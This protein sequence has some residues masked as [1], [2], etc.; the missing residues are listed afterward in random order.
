MDTKRVVQLRSMCIAELYIWS[1]KAKVECS[2]S[3]IVSYNQNSTLFLSVVRSMCERKIWR[4]RCW[5]SDIEQWRRGIWT[6]WSF[7][8][9]T[10]CTLVWTGCAE[11]CPASLSLQS[12]R[13][14]SVDVF[15]RLRFVCVDWPNRALRLPLWISPARM[16]W[17]SMWRVDGEMLK[18]SST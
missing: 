5:S 3:S 11:Q 4:C 6:C 16:S 18:L 13:C 2:D 12:G 14:L 17:G 7:L 9:C 1:V 10:G 8:F 15:R